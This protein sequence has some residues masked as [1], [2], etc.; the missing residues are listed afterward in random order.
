MKLHSMIL[1]GI[2]YRVMHTD[3][4][5]VP[6]STRHVASSADRDPSKTGFYGYIRPLISQK[7]IFCTE[8]TGDDTISLRDPVIRATGAL[9][10]IRAPPF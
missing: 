5:W 9:P 6:L 2:G 7:A 10:L 8:T 1:T 4:L 3:T